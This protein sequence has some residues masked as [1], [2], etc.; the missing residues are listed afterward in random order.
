MARIDIS[1]EQVLT[2]ALIQLKP[3]AMRDALGDGAILFRIY[4]MLGPNWADALVEASCIHDQEESIAFNWANHTLVQLLEDPKRLL[5]IK[6]FDTIALSY[7]N[8]FWYKDV[9]LLTA[10]YGPDRHVLYRPVLAARCSTC[11]YLLLKGWATCMRC[12]ESRFQCWG[13]PEYWYD[14]RVEWTWSS[15]GFF[16][17]VIAHTDPFE[18]TEE[19]RARTDRLRQYAAK[20][21]GKRRDKKT[22]RRIAKRR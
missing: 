14:P 5:V 10:R 4:S 7:H 21:R 11:K 18:V 17:E 12:W 19:E 6:F 15:S 20:A 9:V 2:F 22:G 1:L 3:C 13:R 8:W 16:E